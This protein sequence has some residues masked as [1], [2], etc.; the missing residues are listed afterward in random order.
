[1]P[2]R[3]DPARPPAGLRIAIALL[4]LAA[5]LYVIY[6]TLHTARYAV[7][8]CVSYQG[9]SACR[10]AEGRT[11]QEALR[12]AHDNACSQI[13]SGVTGTIGCQDTPATRVQWKSPQ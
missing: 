1:P 13:T 5:V 2:G 7:E 12:A 6:A 3:G 9:Q 11:Q 4:I 8:V 10:T